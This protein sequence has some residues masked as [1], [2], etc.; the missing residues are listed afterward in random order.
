MEDTPSRARPKYNGTLQNRVPALSHSTQTSFLFF[1]SL[2]SLSLSV[3]RRTGAGGA[4]GA[5][6]GAARGAGAG[7]ARGAGAGAA[8]GAGAGAARGAGAGAASTMRA[9]CAAT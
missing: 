8:R 7:A 9:G 5:G 1:F 6:A 2:I 4:R 3:Y